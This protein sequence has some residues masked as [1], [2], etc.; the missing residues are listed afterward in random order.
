MMRRTT[1][2]ITDVSCGNAAALVGIDQFFL[3][4]GTLTTVENVHNTADKYSVSPVVKIAVIPKDRRGSIQLDQSTEKET[5]L[6]LRDQDGLQHFIQ[7]A[8]KIR[9]DLEQDDELERQPTTC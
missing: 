5:D 3:K 4:L 9:Q 2:Q 7:Q 6:Y 1:E 8:K